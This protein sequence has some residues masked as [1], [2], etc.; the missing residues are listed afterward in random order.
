MLEK[1]YGDY[2]KTV[3]D[4][5]LE[6]LMLVDPDGR[7]VFV[8]RAFEQLSGYSFDE[9][10]GKSCEVIGCDTCFGT[11]AEGKDKYCALFKEGDVRRRKCIFKRKDG[12]VVHVLKN[13]ATIKDQNGK[14]VGGVENMTDLSPLVAQ[15]EVITKLRKQLQGMDGFHGMLGSSLPMLKVFDLITSA[16]SSEAPVIIYGESGTGKEMVAAAV[17]RL[18]VR[19]SGP[20]IK[21]NCAALNENLLE[22]ELFGH[23]K[24][25]FTGAEQN[26]IG[27]FEAADKGDIFLDEIGDLPMATQTKLLRVVQEKEFER[28]GDHKPISLDVRV[29]AATNKD[30]EKLMEGGLFREDLYY[31]LNV[32]PIYLP[33][34]RARREDVPV[35]TEAF[36]QRLQLKTGK[37]ITGIG[38]DAM[39]HLLA[40]DWPGNVRELINA[41]EYAFVLCPQGEI[42]CEHL[43][44]KIGSRVE[45]VTVPRS[46]S[47]S[48]SV[49]QE[50]RR[51]LLEALRASGGN[52]TAAARLLGVSRVTLWKRLKKHNIQGEY[53]LYEPGN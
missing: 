53:Q 40:Y 27:R 39:E 35:L 18:G 37:S 10:V 45:C 19:T 16:A 42:T 23:V 48:G 8:N 43:P 7:I 28:V 51:K 52:K 33:P 1:V 32:I 26:R 14:V 9:L 15:E 44:A 30:L 41:V 11:R 13:A 2:W 22:S 24:G 46:E 20:Y 25:A 49:Q 31:R 50:E 5:M 29:I 34:L 47:I 36:M 38:K 4:T 12:T 3:I 17:H 6:G 21:V